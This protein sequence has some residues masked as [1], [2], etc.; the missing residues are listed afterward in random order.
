MGREG[1][2][3]RDWRGGRGREKDP[4]YHARPLIFTVTYKSLD[5]DLIDG[6]PK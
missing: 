1:R 3:W 4:K 6:L 5:G 2:R